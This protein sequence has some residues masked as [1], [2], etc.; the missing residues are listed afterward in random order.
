ME[1]KRYREHNGE[2]RPLCMGNNNTC[3]NLADYKETRNGKKKYKLKCSKHRRPYNQPAS[4]NNPKS[5]RF[6][7]LDN[8]ALCDAKYRLERHRIQ[9]NT[10]YTPK[11]V[12]VLC[13]TCHQ[14][15]HKFEKVLATKNYH[16]KRVRELRSKFE[17][18]K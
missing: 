5:R 3:S 6:I 4:F 1:H 9:R 17:T 14:L 18:G 16:I 2:T 8:C 13:Q 7:P 11:R 10:I 15:A 12:I